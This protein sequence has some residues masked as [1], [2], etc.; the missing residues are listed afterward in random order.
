MKNL[1][2]SILGLLCL[3]SCTKFLKEEPRS[4]IPV[5]G[6]FNSI[7]E[8]QSAVNFLYDKGNGTGRFFNLNG[9]FDGSQSFSLDIFSG[10]TDNFIA[11]NPAVRYYASLTQTADNQDG[12]LDGVWAGF[13]SNIASANTIIAALDANKNIN[14]DVK[15]PLLGTARFFRAMDYYYLVRMWGAVPLILKPYTSVTNVNAPRASVDSVYD[16]IVADLVWAKNNGNLADKPMGDNGNRISKG[17][18]EA[19]LAEV[20]LTM[21]GYPLKKGNP[22]YQN[23]LSTAKDLLASNGGYALFQSSGGTT[24]FDKFRLTSYDQGNAYLYFIEYNGDIQSSGLPIVTLPNGFPKNVPNSNLKIQYSILANTWVPSKRLLNM[25]DSTN[26]IRRHNRQFYASSFSYIDNSGANKTI[27]FPSVLPYIWYDSVA[28][29]QTA[30]SSKY[31][32]VYRMD[33][34]YLIAAEAANELN[35]DPTPYLQPILDRAYV[36]PPAIPSGQTARRS[37]IL[38]ERYRELAMEGHFWFDMIR[39]RLYPDVSSSHQITFSDFIGHDNGRGEKFTQKDLLLPLPV[40]EMQ[41]D[42]SLRPQNPGY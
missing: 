1:I 17:T 2:V 37:L 27:E 34:I 26:D 28:L 4:S 14:T 16:A 18:V 31:L 41:R 25:Y 8:V 32:S 6:Y 20:Y 13:Y 29:F 36:N 12:Y 24:P 30:H 33:D 21:G 15:A 23:A 38:A 10:M 19:V 9:A 7:E 39:T 11:Q 40:T 35:E 42:P 22:A 5:D 3:S